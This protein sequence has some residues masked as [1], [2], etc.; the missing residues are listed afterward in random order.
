V[1]D[2]TP[3]SCTRRTSRY[4]LPR[5]QNALK[6]EFPLVLERIRLYN[7]QLATRKARML[8]VL[9][10]VSEAKLLLTIPLVALTAATFSGRSAIRRVGLGTSDRA[11]YT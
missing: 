3:S 9:Q 8:A 1:W 11:W 4:E 10:I 5:T 2:G 7:V 6:D